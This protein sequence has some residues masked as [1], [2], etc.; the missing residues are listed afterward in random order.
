[1]DRFHT[2]DDAPMDDGPRG[3]LEA[4]LDPCVDAWTWCDSPDRSVHL[5]VVSD[6]ES[7]E[8]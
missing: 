6:H 2:R 1:M 3:R 8:F 5:R 7:V 4:L